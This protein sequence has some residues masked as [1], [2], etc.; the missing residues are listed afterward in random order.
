MELGF[1]SESR[2]RCAMSVLDKHQLPRCL[3]VAR[4]VDLLI[5]A[6]RSFAIEVRS[7]ITGRDEVETERDQLARYIVCGACLTFEHSASDFRAEPDEPR[8]D[9]GRH[10]PPSF[11]RAIP[12]RRRTLSRHPSISSEVSNRSTH[13]ICSSRYAISAST[14]RVDVAAHDMTNNATA[15]R[16]LMALLS[17]FP[18]GRSRSPRRR[19]ERRQAAQTRSRRPSAP[20]P[21]TH[22]PLLAFSART[23]T[24]PT[25]RPEELV[26]RDRHVSV[27]P[28][29]LRI[30]ESH[31]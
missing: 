23:P 19:R 20:R 28:G 30:D 11:V 22:S 16:A 9:G 2:L 27:T 14:L 15:A 5:D 3:R 1:P 7:K 13:A 4:A 6:C 17:F 24:S 25:L 31:S 26:F 29:A 10:G 12:H 21:T 8:N 18:Q